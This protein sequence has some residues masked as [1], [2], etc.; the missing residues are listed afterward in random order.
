MRNK[1]K[2]T[3]LR[4]INSFMT[5]SPR[6]TKHVDPF[7]KFQRIVITVKYNKFND[8]ESGNVQCFLPRCQKS[9]VFVA[10][11]VIALPNIYWDPTPYTDLAHKHQNWT[12]V[13]DSNKRTSVHQAKMLLISLRAQDYGQVCTSIIMKD[14]LRQLRNKF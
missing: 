9:R 2:Q 5:L 11:L 14:P 8:L 4:S 10:L 13:A 12:V 7:H 1:R 3:S 6:E